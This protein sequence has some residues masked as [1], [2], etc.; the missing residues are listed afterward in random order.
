MTSRTCFK[1]YAVGVGTDHH[2]EGMLPSIYKHGTP[3]SYY[4]RLVKLL[5]P[6]KRYLVTLGGCLHNPSRPRDR[7]QQREINISR[8]FSRIESAF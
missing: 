7:F 4:P 6:W 2:S 1:L 3:H 8:L 5:R